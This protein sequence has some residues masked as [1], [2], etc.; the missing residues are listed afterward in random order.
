MRT[1]VRRVQVSLLRMH[2]R[3]DGQ[4]RK[5]CAHAGSRQRSARGSGAILRPLC[6]S[7]GRTRSISRHFRLW[8]AWAQG[9][10][11]CGQTRVRAP[12]MF[13]G[14][15]PPSARCNA[16]FPVTRKD[17]SCCTPKIWP[18]RPSLLRSPVAPVVVAGIVAARKSCRACRDPKSDPAVEQLPNANTQEG[19]GAAGAAQIYESSGPSSIGTLAWPQPPPRVS[20]TAEGRRYHRD[21]AVLEGPSVAFAS[22]PQWAARR[23][24]GRLPPFR[25]GPQHTLLR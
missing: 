16:R 18:L 7:G 1:V 23:I 9:I 20:S 17:D 22:R 3:I 19:I 13:D 10:Q 8:L 15:S 2:A 14:D 12:A 4:Q 21:A 11:R 25:V 6:G 24:A 5:G